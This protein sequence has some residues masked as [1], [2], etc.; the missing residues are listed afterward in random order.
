MYQ[1]TFR[2]TIA[3]VANVELSAVQITTIQAVND[4]RRR[5]LLTKD[6]QIG[7]VVKTND[8]ETAVLVSERLTQ[9]RINKEL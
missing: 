6:I 2:K 3:N 9:E 1:N 5:R 8:Q 4:L 7:V